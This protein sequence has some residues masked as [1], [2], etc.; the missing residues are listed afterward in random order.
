MLTAIAT[1]GHTAGALSW[2]WVSCDGG[3]CRTIVYADSLSPVSRD[4]YRFSDH[5]AWLTAYRASITKIAASP[6]E[7]LITPHP[8][9]SQMSQR[10]ALGR[11][12]LDENACR[13]YAATK[14]KDLD[15]R[16]A[17]E[18]AATAPVK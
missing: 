15:D 6:C 1:P 4:G 3:V 5:P 18:A 7:I 10:F 17:K 2:R 8:S 14:T 12:L 9:A 11:P 16:L 13:T